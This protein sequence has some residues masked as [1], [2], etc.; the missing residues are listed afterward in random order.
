MVRYFSKAG[1]G[2]I[3]FN[4]PDSKVNVLSAANLGDL[5]QIL[6]DI[7]SANRNISALFFMS[8][9]KDMFVAGADIKELASI[10]SKDEALKLCAKGQDICNRIEQL[11]MPT[12]AVVDGACIGGGLE[13]GLSCDYILATPN[14]KVKIGF[15]ETRFEISPGFGGVHRLKEKIGRKKAERLIRTGQLLSALEAKKAN[16]VDKIIP[17]KIARE[18]EALS[19]F[20]GWRKRAISEPRHQLDEEERGILAEKITQEPARNALAAFLLAS[21]YKNRIPKENAG[22]EILRRCA[23]IGAGAMGRDIAYLISLETGMEVGITD[24]NRAVLKTAGSYIK[25]IY[26]DA[27]KR[28]ML[29]RSEASQRFKRISFSKLHLEDCDL[30]IECIAEDPQLKKQLFAKIEKMVHGD[31]IIA[32]NTSCL[33]I[34]GFGPCL[35]RPERFIGI[36]FFNPAYKMKLVEVTPGSLTDRRV[37]DKVNIFLQSMR[38]VPV[39]VKDSPGFLV[40]RMLLPYLNEAVF[41]VEEGYS[42]LDIDSAMLGFGMPKGPID[43]LEDIGLEVA[44][45]ASRILE[46]RSGGRIRVSGIFG[47]WA[48][49]KRIL[50]AKQIRKADG[51]YIAQRLL[52]P[53]KKEAELCLKEGIAVSREIIDL[54][55]LLGSGFPASKRIWDI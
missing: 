13:L 24:I 16:I 12:F 19:G 34:E 27:V 23:V 8:S 25:S 31:C 11:P 42:I 2:I 38:R 14:K 17:E 47:L 45:K 10:S 52:G 32:T 28:H 35:G 7:S 33:S 6:S 4:D 43:L 51:S 48:E 46:D 49:A 53:M 36:H 44:Y 26:R 55:L 40:N 9:K 22:R 18:Y 21:R 1:V 30:V 20:S 15:P 3:E 5:E 37:L 39:T 50:P 29:S 54:A 41:M